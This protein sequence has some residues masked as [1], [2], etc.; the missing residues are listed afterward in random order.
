MQIREKS[1]YVRECV[2]ARTCVHKVYRGRLDQENPVGNLR[3]LLD[4]SCS[5]ELDAAVFVGTLYMS[6]KVNFV[7]SN[8]NYFVLS[9]CSFWFWV[10][11]IGPRYYDYSWHGMA[12]R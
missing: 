10:R 8:S 5:I 7:F 12:W 6:W 9:M 2:S 11:H 3:H 4:G 1:V